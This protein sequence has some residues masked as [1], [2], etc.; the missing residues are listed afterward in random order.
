MATY[1]SHRPRAYAQSKLSTMLARWNGPAGAAVREYGPFIWDYVPAQAL[2][3]FS[4]NSQG[5]SE[6]VSGSFYAIGLYN[7]PTGNASTLANGGAW[8]RIAT[9]EL[10]R[11]ITGHQGH[12]GAGWENVIEDQVVIGLIDYRDGIA[13][14]ANQ[15]PEDIRPRDLSSQWSWAC[16]AMGYVTATGAVLAINEHL[17]QLRAVNE[18]YRFGALLAATAESGFTQQTAYPLV[19]AW[20][21]LETGKALAA[22]T[23]GDLRWFDLGLGQYTDAVEHRITVAQ[24]GQPDCALQPGAEG[25][26]GMEIRG[27]MGNVVLGVLGAGALIWVGSE[28]LKGQRR[29]NP[30]GRRL[31]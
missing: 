13:N 6:V 15:I 14:V 11:R 21:R 10:F 24:Y 1:C 7:T 25:P 12:L 29:A 31:R 28:V 16:G 26:V 18:D 22:Q 27:G 4:A 30:R 20:Q 17:P 3:S 5:P 2:M 8:R 19:R 9:G 23:G